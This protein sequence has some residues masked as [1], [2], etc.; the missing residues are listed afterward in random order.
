MSSHARP[1]FWPLRIVEG[2]GRNVIQISSDIFSFLR[3]FKQTLVAAVVPPYRIKDIFAQTFFVAN[4]SV[5]IVCL[6]VTAAAMVTML[7]ASFHMKIVVQND[8]MV[9][10]FASLLILRELGT[11]TMALLVTSRVGAGY[12][13]E[14]GSMQISEQIDALKMLGIQPIRFL[15]VP[16]FVACIFSGFLLAVIANLVCL[17]GAMLVSTVILGYTG[18]MFLA[19]MRTFVHFQDLVFAAIKGCVFGAII[20]LFSCWYGFRCREGAEAVGRATTNSVVSTS[21]A[22]IVLDFLMTYIFTFF[23]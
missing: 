15:V 11:V 17:A 13:A 21:I 2:I 14:I 22:I 5:W 6:C 23:Y 3:L 9:P 18:G 10:G 8:S 4:E 1:I 16:R 20:P 12:A 19:S 7:E